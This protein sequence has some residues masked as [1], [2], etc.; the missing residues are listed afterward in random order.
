MKYVKTRTLTTPYDY[1]LQ[2][3]WTNNPTNKPLTDNVESCDYRSK[4]EN[5]FRLGKS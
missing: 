5:V 4:V 2:D 1:E 3:L